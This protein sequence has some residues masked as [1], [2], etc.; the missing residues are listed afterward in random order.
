ME[1]TKPKPK[2]V[3]F[4]LKKI[5]YFHIYFSKQNSVNENYKPCNSRNKAKKY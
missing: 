4:F 5:Q 1:V 3:T 2:K